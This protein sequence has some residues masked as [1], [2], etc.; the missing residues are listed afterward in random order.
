VGI[1][2]RL[3]SFKEDGQKVSNEQIKEFLLEEIAGDGYNYGYRK[4]TKVLQRKYKLK[5]N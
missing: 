5:I 1:I 3:H 2:W 4:L